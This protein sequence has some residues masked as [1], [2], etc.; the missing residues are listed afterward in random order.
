MDF[1]HCSGLIN[2]KVAIDWYLL[3]CDK[4]V[5]KVSSCESDNIQLRSLLKFKVFLFA[6][7]R[8]LSYSAVTIVTEVFY[9]SY[10][11]LLPIATGLDLF[12]V[13]KAKDL[14]YI[15]NLHMNWLFELRRLSFF[16]DS[17]YFLASGVIPHD[18]ESLGHFVLKWLAFADGLL[19]TIFIIIFDIIIGI[20]ISATMCTIVYCAKW[21]VTKCLITCNV[22]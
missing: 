17:T 8:R 16:K 12:K 18:Y 10:K 2:L 20:I 19:M 3:H 14:R 5:V 4:G 22:S 9:V 7:S 13:Y 6:I 11:A 21:I 1:Y 15:S